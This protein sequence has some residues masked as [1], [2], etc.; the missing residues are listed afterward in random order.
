MS[1]TQTPIQVMKAR[2]FEASALMKMLPKASDGD[3]AEEV[4]VVTDRLI[5]EA[6]DEIEKLDK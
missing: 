2:L 6:L 1:E 5:N 4:A 3:D